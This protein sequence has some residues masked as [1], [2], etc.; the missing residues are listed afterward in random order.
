MPFMNS[1]L[2]D[3]ILPIGAIVKKIQDETGRHNIDNISRTDAY[4]QFY[5]RHPEIKWAFLASMV[6][7]NAGWNMCDLEGDWM[8]RL[9]DESTRRLLYLTY[10][11]ANWLI[12]H[13]AYPQL[14]LYHYSTK[15]G[16]PLFHLLRFFNVSD[17]M[18]KE[19]SI[20]WK[21]KDERR[22]MTSLIIN[23]QN[24]IQKPVLNHSLYK[25]QVFHSLVFSLQDWF[26]FSVVIFPTLEGELFGASVSGFRST[27]NRIDLGKRLAG[28]L[29]HQEYYPRFLQFAKKT[30][31]T[32]ARA[33]YER[34]I[35]FKL[36]R[37]TPALRC[38]FPIVQHHIHQYSDWS[39]GKRIKRS[40]KELPKG[41]KE[42]TELTK[43]YKKKQLQIEIAVSLK[44]I[45]S[46]YKQQSK[47]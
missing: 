9:L 6:S 7:R 47:G 34:L 1:L 5:K 25:K 28:V 31:H 19:W 37:E 30:I 39:K 36:R 40:W 12:F 45:Y 27:G 22:L 16:R 29:F 15:W 41:S 44:E 11:R 2:D 43:W 24:V 42:R 4:F 33:D 20:F 14:L 46:L 38:T 8:P 32:G 13:D 21:E 26:H 18:A 23:E 3:E 35:P 17:F 10:E